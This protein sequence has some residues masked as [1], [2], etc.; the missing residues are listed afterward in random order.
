MLDRAPPE[1]LLI[2]RLSDAWCGLP[3]SRVIETMRPLPLL[4]FAEAPPW[5]C[6]LALIRGEPTPV[7]DGNRLIT[8]PA[9]TIRRF[10]TVRVAGR[11]AALAVEHVRGILRLDADGWQALPPLLQDAGQ[12][13]IRAIGRLDGD[14]MLFLE[15]AR[16]V[17]DT[18]WESL[19]RQWNAS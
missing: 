6:G 1:A 14:L 18:A 7:V 5:M 13:V 17:P 10:V 16:L 2:C 11:Q 15:T 9:Q 3:L 12:E 8:G 19:D 4:P